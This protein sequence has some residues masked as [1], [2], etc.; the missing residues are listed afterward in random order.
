[1]N[2]VPTADGGDM[3]FID[4]TVLANNPAYTNDRIPRAYP[5]PTISSGWNTSSKRSGVR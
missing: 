4:N 5:C 3:A 2:G 1:M